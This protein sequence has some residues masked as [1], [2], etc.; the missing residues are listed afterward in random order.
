MRRLSWVP[1]R[2]GHGDLAGDGA[3]RLLGTSM[4]RPML[5]LRETVQNSW[6]A[7]LPEHIPTYEMRFRTLEPAAM[8]CLRDTVVT[9]CRPGSELEGFLGAM[10]GEAIEIVDRGTCGLGG[11]T[12]ND[13]IAGGSGTNYR[14]FVL[15]VGAPRDRKNG[16][17]T[18]GFGK[19]AAFA[20]SRCGTVVI[21]TRVRNGGG[22]FEDRLV[23]ACVE[24]SFNMDGS[25]FTGQQWWGVVTSS[26]GKF[27]PVRGREA[28][29]I[30][31]AMFE[32]GFEEAE[33]GTSILLLDPIYGD[34]RTAFVDDV[35]RAVAPNLWPK[36]IA[37][38]PAE[39]SMDIRIIDHGVPRPA[40]TSSES[41]VL[42]ARER[43][44]QVLR[45]DLQDPFVA[46]GVAEHKTLGRRIGRVAIAPV[47]PDDD[48]PLK[49]SVNTVTL[50]RDAELVV[51]DRE[52][53]RVESTVGDWVA[54]FKPD[55][56]VDDVFAAAEPP[57]H[58]TWSAE[59]LTEKDKKLVGHLLRRELNRIVKERVV[60]PD[61]EDR[62]ESA[63]SSGAIAAALG[64]LMG[65]VGGSAAS[66][67]QRRRRRATGRR[68]STTRVETLDWSLLPRDPKHPGDRT[69]V[70]L[71]VHS[72]ERVEL[73]GTVAIRIDGGRGDEDGSAFIESWLFEDGTQVPEDTVRVE[74]GTNVDAIVVTPEDVA[75]T[76]TFTGRAVQ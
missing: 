49:D 66:P 7:R 13:E 51:E 26:D 35:V 70:R 48:D 60:P 36:L 38:Q 52:L 56:E 3:T 27:D 9:Q 42:E 16:G 37:G 45:G 14:D 40:L 20:A 32:R 43:C 74:G 11:P 8:R 67:T 58:D 73:S 54:V 4:P 75:F 1:K 2:F 23:A 71:R 29:E 57:S 59:G 50:M 39:R 21:W 18:Y 72:E 19:S 6:D 22:G 44:L 64:G 41:P 53:P 34:D 24:N 25:R 63:H 46:V 10:S 17:G 61:D 31:R 65:S 68:R 15:T 55:F 28:A 69:R 30:G 33:T 47:H 12:R 5:L 76:C 62:G